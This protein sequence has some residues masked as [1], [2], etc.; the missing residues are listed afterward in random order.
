MLSMTRNYSVHS[1]R[2]VSFMA[3]EKKTPAKAPAQDNAQL[4]ALAHLSILTVVLLGPFCMAIPLI[5]WLIERNKEDKLESVEF[6]AKQ[7]FFF[8]LAALIVTA[9]IGIVAGILSIIIIGLLLLPI[10]ILFPLAAVIYGVYGG[11]KVWN[12]EDF[13]YIYV[14]DF[15]EAGK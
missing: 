12:G 8:Q 1:F 2:E 4:A 7:A 3:A 6:H 10:V 9:A 15:I 11:I 5:I 14:A 13:R